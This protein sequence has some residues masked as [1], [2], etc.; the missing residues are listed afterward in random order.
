[1]DFGEIGFVL[2]SIV[3]QIHGLLGGTVVEILGF[4]NNT[5][6]GGS[7]LLS[8]TEVYVQEF[9]NSIEGPLLLG[10]SVVEV[11]EVGE[12]VEACK[13]PWVL[14]GAGQEVCACGVS[15]AR[16]SPP[17]TACPPWAL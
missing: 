4:L 10:G 6:I 12:V 14:A 17:L 16:T 9:R 8:S 11:A 1:M 15:P 5:E 7:E 3:V 2:E 13:E